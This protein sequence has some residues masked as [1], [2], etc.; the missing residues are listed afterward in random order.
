MRDKIIVIDDE[1]NLRKILEA[2][3]SRQGF[4]VFSFEGF[5]QA[6]TTLNTED[7]SAVITDLS[8]PEHSGLDVLKYCKEYSPDLPVVLI[9]AFGTVEAAVTALKNG[10]FDFV[11]K[12]FDQDELIRIIEKAIQTRKRR[13]REPALEMMSATAVGPVPVP[14]FGQDP[15][16]VS[17]REEVYRI[18]ATRSP[19]FMKGEIGSGKRSVAYEIHRKSDRSR[20]P[21]I[22]VHCD[23]IPPVF[24][25]SELFGTEKGPSPTSFFSKPGSFEL[26]MGGTVFLDEVDALGVDAQNALFT[27]LENE[28]F[29][30]VHGAKIYPLDFRIITASSKD[31]DRRVLD[32]TFHVELY[33]RL[34]LEQIQLKPLRERKQDIR[35]DLLPYFIDQ[36]CRKRGIPNPGMDP[37]VADWFVQ[38]E[39]KGNIGELQRAVEKMMNHWVSGPVTVDLLHHLGPV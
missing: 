1:P 11:L 21:F 10:A 2:F 29:S 38:Q 25:V 19:V 35:T 23:A 6:I 5:Q 15:S 37:S 8:M 39:W 9:T 7:V 27:M 22:H 12:P 20:G 26:G 36:S 4:E 24:Q 34:T 17:L 30:R 28:S 33:P 32:G 31:L 16:T 3:L 14:L 18:S 13:R